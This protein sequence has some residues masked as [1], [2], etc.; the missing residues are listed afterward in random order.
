MKLSIFVCYKCGNDAQALK[1]A[2]VRCTKCG[3]VMWE[4]KEFKNGEKI[5]EEMILC[6]KSQYFEED[7]EEEEDGE[8]KIIEFTEK[9]EKDFPSVKVMKT[10]MKGPKPSE[11]FR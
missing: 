1:G 3:R 8:E 11:L 7:E 5:R 4:D 6:F 9:L 10:I 2:S